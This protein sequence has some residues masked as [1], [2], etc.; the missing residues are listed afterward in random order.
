MRGMVR[1][2]RR[3]SLPMALRMSATHRIKESSV[4]T[5]SPQNR[6]DDVVLAYKMARILSKQPQHSKGPG[7]N[8]YMLARGVSQLIRVEINHMTWQSHF[9]LRCA[10]PIA[11]HGTIPGGTAKFSPSFPSEQVFFLGFE[12]LPVESTV[13]LHS[14]GSSWACA[15]LVRLERTSL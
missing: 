8:I 9:T 15:F 13:S 5:T 11:G 7:P 1:R 6:A 3:S 4:T 10:G 2:I 12:L 14:N